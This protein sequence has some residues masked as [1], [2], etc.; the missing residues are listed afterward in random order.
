MTPSRCGATLTVARPEWAID[1]NRWRVS[2]NLAGGHEG[3]HQATIRFGEWEADGAQPGI[4]HL[5]KEGAL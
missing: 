2:C 3:R 5:P 4:Y 1:G